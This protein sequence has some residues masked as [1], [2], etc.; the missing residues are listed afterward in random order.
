[1]ALFL[2]ERKDK[3]SEKHEVK[4]EYCRHCRHLFVGDGK[5]GSFSNSSCLG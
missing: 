5:D 4:I 2:H 1:V 3:K